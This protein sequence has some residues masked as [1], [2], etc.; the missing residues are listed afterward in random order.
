VGRV[1]PPKPPV[2]MPAHCDVP[3][4]FDVPEEDEEL[5]QA[6]STPTPASAA[7][8]APAHRTVSAFLRRSLIPHLTV[9]CRT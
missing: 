5:E 8:A 3:V 7:I 4:E 2:G 9:G 1:P 6:V